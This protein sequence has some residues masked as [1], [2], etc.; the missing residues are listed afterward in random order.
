MLA[1]SPQ[2]LPSFSHSRHLN[3][4]AQ[5]PVR[6]NRARAHPHA[7]ETMGHWRPVALAKPKEGLAPLRPLRVQYPSLIKPDV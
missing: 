4:T 6:C 3:V 5:V 1:L 7:M 2:A